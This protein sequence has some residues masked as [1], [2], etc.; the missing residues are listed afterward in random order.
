MSLTVS[1]K[2]RPFDSEGEE[3][4]FCC[5]FPYREGEEEAEEARGRPRGRWQRCPTL[6]RLPG[7]GLCQPIQA[8]AATPANQS[9]LEQSLASQSELRQSPADQSELRQ[10]AVPASGRAESRLCGGAEPTC[11]ALAE[12]VVGLCRSLLVW[13]F[14]IFLKACCSFYFDYFI[15]IFLE[16]EGSVYNVL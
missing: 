10:P 5:G 12:V 2:P 11:P 8:Q 14:D 15:I 4:F 7:S 9:E 6:P 1:I 13:Q 16:G 3:D